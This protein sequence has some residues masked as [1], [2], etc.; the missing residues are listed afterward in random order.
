MA[1]TRKRFADIRRGSE[2]AYRKNLD[3]ARA[4]L[5]DAN[6]AEMRALLGKT[7]EEVARL[8]GTAQS[9]ISQTEARDDHMVSTLRAYVEALGGQLEITARFGDKKIHLR[10]V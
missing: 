7:Q 1:K 8:V 2:E 5:I 4:E 6:L 10:G 3:A 9:H